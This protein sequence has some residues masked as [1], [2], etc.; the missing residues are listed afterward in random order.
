MPTRDDY[1]PSFG[2]DY[3]GDVLLIETEDDYTGELQSQQ[4]AER[5][6]FDEPDRVRVG[7]PP[8]ASVVQAAERILGMTQ[9]GH[10]F[11]V[12]TV[13][14]DPAKA[15]QTRCRYCNEPMAKTATEWLC[16]FGRRGW[17]GCSCNWCLCRQQYQAGRYRGAGRPR[18]QC[19]APECKRR[20]DAERKRKS[21]AG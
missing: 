19:G 14:R 21:R 4:W 11:A 16:E 9:A 20:H 15:V 10:G 12:Q 18:V 13:T 7:R 8:E 1:L 17:D 2:T 6:R 5:H 3:A